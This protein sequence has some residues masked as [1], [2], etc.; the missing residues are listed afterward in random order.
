[1]KRFNF[2][3]QTKSV[4]F[5]AGS[6]SAYGK[7]NY[8]NWCWGCWYCSRHK[9]HIEWLSEYFNFR[10]TRSN[11]RPYSYD[12]I[13]CKCFRFGSPMV[14]HSHHMEFSLCLFQFAKSNGVCMFCVC[15]RSGVMAKRIML[16]TAW[17]RIK[18]Y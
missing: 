16:F 18:I 3:K 11:R 6:K 12:S 15:V 10:R 2:N 4:I 1:M 14:T 9:A 5:F 17:Q 13:R 7:A 8:N